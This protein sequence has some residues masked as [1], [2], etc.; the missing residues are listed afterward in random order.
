MPDC[1]TIDRPGIYEGFPVEAYFGDPCPTPSLNQSLAKLLLERA[2]IHAKYAHPRLAPMVAEEDDAA[3]KYNADRAIGNAAHSLILGRGK[4]VAIGEFP[5][6]MTKAAKEFKAMAMADGDEPILR[7]HYDRAFALASSVKADL[8]NHQCCDVFTGPGQ[9][10]AVIAWEEDGLWFR[11]MIDFLSED[12]RRCDD[13]KTTSLS[14]APESIPNQMDDFGWPIQA[15]MWE[16]GL[17]VLDPSNAGRRRYRFVCVEN[18]PPFALTVNEIS[19]AELTI[20]RRKL[21]VA[22]AIWRKCL[23]SGEWP[24]YPQTTQYPSTPGYRLVRWEAR[25]L[26]LREAGR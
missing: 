14:A 3:E 25:E 19:E 6:W 17:N 10:E 16:R 22:V 21:D 20:G 12:L 23:T 24:G 4:L 9:F 1:T 18:E 7:K 11:T 26:E 8:A 5:N 15:A 2:P 13:L